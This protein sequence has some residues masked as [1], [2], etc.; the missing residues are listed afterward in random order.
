MCIRCFLWSCHYVSLFMKDLVYSLSWIESLCW[1]ITKA[2]HTV[3]I[4]VPSMSVRWCVPG[5]TSKAIWKGWAKFLESQAVTRMEREW[6]HITQSGKM[7]E[8]R[9]LSAEIMENVAAFITFITSTLWHFSV[10]MTERDTKHQPIRCN[11]PSRTKAKTLTNALNLD[12]CI[13]QSSMITEVI[14]CA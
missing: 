2:H 5:Q 4:K 6:Q 13:C 10:F 8:K 9:L 1:P 12:N 7:D 11:I 14:W 3:T